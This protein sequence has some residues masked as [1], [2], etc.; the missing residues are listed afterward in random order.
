MA[1]NNMKQLNI[2][3]TLLAATVISLSMFA[4][5]DTVSAQVPD[6]Q[7]S[8]ADPS[9]VEEQMRAPEMMAAPQAK[10]EIG[11][12]Y[13]QSMPEGADKIVFTI[14]ALVVEGV[15][16]YQNGEL[17]GVYADRLG[18]TMTLAD[19]YGIAAELTRFYRQDGYVLTQVVVPP[20]TIEN[21]VAR[22]QVVEG[23]ID[24]IVI[25]APEEEGRAADL[26]RDYAAHLKMKGA[27]NIEDLEKW[28]LLINDLPGVSA[29]SVI[30]PSK[31]KT[32]GAD[33][34]I[35]VTRDPYDG[36]LGI[37]NYGSRYLGPLQ[38]T[39]SFSANSH[40]NRNE[41][42]TGTVVVAPDT[43]WDREMSYAALAYKQP[44]GT[45]GTTVELFGSYADTEPGYNLDTFDVE[46]RSRA[47]SLTVEHPVVRSRAKNL[48]IR[49]VFDIRE[50]DTKNNV[51]LTR[52]DNIR[53]LRAGARYEYLDMLF[54]PAYSVMDIEIAH[55]LD[56]LGAS[57]EGDANMSRAAGDPTF[58]K[59][60]A[61]YQRL[62][63]LTQDWNLL[64]AVR[65]QW[66]SDALLSSEEFGVGGVNYG[67]GFDPSEIIGDDGIAG[68][69]E[70]QWTEPAEIDLLDTYYVF[71]FYDAGRVWNKDATT[72]SE[73]RD[74]VTSA[75]LGVSADFTKDT[76]LDMMLA[77]PLNRDVETQNDRDPRFYM[78]LRH[79]F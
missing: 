47:L 36:L 16:V 20:Q 29:R 5:A 71:G 50:V 75:G 66:A 61:T 23:F 54:G 12:L 69:V 53:A 31:D 57:K 18:Q 19:L 26:I 4:G 39:G 63:R 64:T 59:V 38:L 14:S 49:G 25:D 74:T 67:R 30:S 60:N 70:L 17:A 41:R 43:D 22:L 27:L 73:K 79:R 48:K 76:T 77:F 68:K 35:I 56:V 62:Q 21:G 32:G 2:R 51:E 15:N 52:H 44:V 11:K 45:K 37:D 72:S 33:I 24:N 6:A 7:R 42:I 1:R 58:M 40:F 8:V 13:T 34:R 46:G 28:L 9:R 78:G 65:G 3:H 55:G 10:I